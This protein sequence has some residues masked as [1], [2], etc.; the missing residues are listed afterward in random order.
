MEP[1]PHKPGPVSKGYVDI[2]IDLPRPLRDWA[3][4]Q[5]EGVSAL[6]RRPAGGAAPGGT[7]MTGAEMPDTPCEL[8]GDSTPF[9]RLYQDPDHGWDAL[10]PACWRLQQPPDPAPPWPRLPW[11]PGLD[12]PRRGP[13]HQEEAPTEHEEEVW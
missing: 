10:C 2:H 7:R 4:R 13:R 1:H 11:R 12:R 5:P 3:K 6:V 9:L 8:C